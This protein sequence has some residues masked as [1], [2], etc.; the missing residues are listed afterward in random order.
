MLYNSIKTIDNSLREIIPLYSSESQKRRKIVLTNCVTDKSYYK[1][2]YNLYG[3]ALIRYNYGIN[4]YLSD[5]YMYTNG[6]NKR[7]M[8]Y[9]IDR[10]LSIQSFYPLI[11]KLIYATQM[12]NLKKKFGEH[13]Y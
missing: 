10:I 1:E 7:T 5:L 12:A 11:N 4:K 13:T 8:F 2:I 6:F 3:V 9:F